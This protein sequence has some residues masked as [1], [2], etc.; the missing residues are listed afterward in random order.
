MLKMAFRSALAITASS[1]GLAFAPTPAH[2]QLAVISP[3]DPALTN[4]DALACAGYYSGNLLNGSPEDILNQ[5]EAIESLPG[6]FV[7]DGNWDALDPAFKIEA[8]TNGDQLN[9]GTTM[10]GKTVI[11][12]HFGN[13]A[14]PAGNVSV[15]WLFDFGAAGADYIRLD[16]TQGFSNS[17][18]YTTGPAVPEPSVWAMLLIGFFGVAG[19]IRY[20]RRKQRVSVSYA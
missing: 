4:P 18:L 14:G 15:F 10:F 20:S 13:V 19:A 6:D 12:A 7:F 3:C 16:D 2:A 11:G 8:L 5:Q 17:V 9:F 1:L